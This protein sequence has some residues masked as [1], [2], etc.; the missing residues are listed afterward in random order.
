[1]IYFNVVDQKSNNLNPES[2][3]KDFKV[4]DAKKVDKSNYK[5][6]KIE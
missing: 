3:L 5:R 2:E 4:Y 6:D 1:M